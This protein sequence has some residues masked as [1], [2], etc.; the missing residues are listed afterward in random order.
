MHSTVL[1]KFHIIYSLQKTSDGQ[2][3]SISLEVNSD[4]NKLVRS[5]QRKSHASLNETGKLKEK[6]KHQ[7]IE[8]GTQ[9]KNTHNN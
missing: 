1:E 2:N 6:G 9:S 5:V 7:R 8:P 3:K 4:I